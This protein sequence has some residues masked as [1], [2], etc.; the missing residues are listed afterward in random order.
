MRSVARQVHQGET[1]SRNAGIDLARSLAMLGMLIEHEL[2]Y[3]TIQPKSAVWAVYGR[4]APLFVLLAGVGV[5][6]ATRAPRRPLDRAMIVARAP[7]LLLLGMTLSTHV[8][9][10]ILQSFALF[11]LVGALSIRLPRRV[12]A[13]LGVVFLAGGPLFITELR[14]AGRLGAT[15]GFRHDVSFGALQ[16]PVTL[17]NGLALQYY[18][19]AIWLGFFFLGMVLGRADVASL[20]LGRRLFAWAT[21]AA[22]VAFTVGWAGARMFG[23]AREAFSLAPPPPYA[24]SGNWTTYGFSNAVGWAI[25]SAAVALAVTG[26]CIWIAGLLQRSRVISPLVCL[27]AVSLTFYIVHGLYLDTLWHSVQ[28]HLTTPVSIFVAAVVFWLLFA[29][30][31]QRW[32]AYFARGPIEMLLHFGARVLTAPLRVEYMRARSPFRPSSHAAG[33]SLR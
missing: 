1:R 4:S 21:A 27:G 7:L 15:F 8:D 5:S 9:G 14:R 20:A 28:P 11:F 3:P 6:L 26:A 25:S 18:P 2:Q 29:L 23:P 22:V 13:T 32:L 12:L 10:I 31:A 30:V 33:R 17:L 24:W 19:A 16:H